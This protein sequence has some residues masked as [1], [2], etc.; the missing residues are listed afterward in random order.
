MK[1]LSSVFLV[2]I[3][4]VSS[5]SAGNILVEYE[6]RSSADKTNLFYRTKR[7]EVFVLKTKDLEIEA[8]PRF[9]FGPVR[10]TTRFGGVWYTAEK[11]L[12]AF[13]APVLFARLGRLT[14]VTG[15]ELRIKQLSFREVL[16]DRPYQEGFAVCDLDARSALGFFYESYDKDNRTVWVV[17]PRF[18]FKPNSQYLKK[19]SLWAGITD[20]PTAG[21]FFYFGT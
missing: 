2:L 19:I 10:L 8:G 16:I 18:D 7:L 6:S 21:I 17:G 5:I 11:K 20:N 13:V 15:W 12:K 4:L 9:Y 1:I 14:L 3:I